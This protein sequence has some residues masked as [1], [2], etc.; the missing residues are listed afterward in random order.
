MQKQQEAIRVAL[1]ES[2]EASKKLADADAMHAKA[3]EDAKAESAKVTD[4]AKH[5]LGADRRT[6]ARSRRTSTPSASRPKVH[7]RF[8]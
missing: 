3:V 1:A 2:A 8:S 5:G 4:E 6:A 7:S